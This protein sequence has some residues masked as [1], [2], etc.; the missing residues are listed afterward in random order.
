MMPGWW[1]RAASGLAPAGATGGAD[2]PESG[3]ETAWRSQVKARLLVICAILAA[4]AAVLEARLVYLQVVE[5]ADYAESARGQ[6]QTE[7]PV[8]ATRGDIVDRHGEIL[9]YSVGGHRLVANPYKVPA[10]GADDEARALCEALPDCPAGERARFAAELNRKRGYVVLRSA[11]QMSPGAADAIGALLEAR[12]VARQEPVVDL[13]P[14]TRRYYPKQELAAHVVGFV[15]AE[16][17]GAAGIE[18]KYDST[19]AGTSGLRRALVNAKRQEV[20]TIVEREAT[21]GASVELTIDLVLQHEAERALESAVRSSGADAGVVL[22]MVPHTGEILVWASYP[23]FDP[24]RYNV[25]SDRELVNRGLVPYEPGS[26]FKMITASA[27]ISERLMSPS[28]RLD[29]SPGVIQIPGRARPIREARGRDYGVLSL[30]DILIK[31]SNIGAIKTGQL[32]GPDRMMQYARRMGYGQRLLPDLAGESAGQV[33]PASEI[34]ASGLASVA[35]GYEISA[36]PLQVLVGANVIATGGLLIEPRLQRAVVQ[37]GRRQDVAPR[38]RRRALAPV[39]A[40]TMTAMLESVVA[41]GAAR[42]AGLT[43]YRVA[44][45]T[46]TA[47]KVVNGQYSHT[48]YHVSFVGFVPS[49]EPALSILVMIDTPR[50]GEAYGSTF[51]A[52]VFRRVAEAAMTRLGVPPSIHP[53]PPIMTSTTLPASTVRSTMASATSTVAADPTRRVMPNL[54]GLSLREALRYANAMGLELVVEGEGVVVSQTPVAG[55]PL[56]A[57]GAGAL[58]LRRNS[59]TTGIER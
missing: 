42:A 31:S 19:I 47:A 43:R 2:R 49:R 34:T 15:N 37:D 44:G 16:G 13:E 14:E 32:V 58:R 39:V 12:R 25:A 46:G 51:A 53:A 20:F 22:A 23:T 50:Q 28:D 9:A 54:I 38:V 17:A 26:T 27:A 1:T 55:A 10:G 7:I 35:M 30:E 3:F 6:Q 33:K 56:P 41:E 45:K 21:P 40:E 5:H 59:G 36:T 11:R 18:A 57:S 4:W 29:T 8:T 48:D 52:P 24:N